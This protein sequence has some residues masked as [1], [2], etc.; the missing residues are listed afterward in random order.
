LIL[1][2]SDI[3]NRDRIYS[4]GSGYHGSITQPVVGY[5]G[6]IRPGPDISDLEL[7]LRL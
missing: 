3:S 2:E 5:V 4:T 6:Y 1:I 7:I